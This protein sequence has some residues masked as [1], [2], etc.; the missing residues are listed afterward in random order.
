MGERR[1]G[2]FYYK[3]N[4]SIGTTYGPWWLIWEL[5]MVKNTWGRLVLR[6]LDEE[7]DGV[8][9]YCVCMQGASES[10]ILMYRSLQSPDT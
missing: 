2:D 10:S 1:D 7:T 3:E 8:V 6:V 5:S 4:C 9:V